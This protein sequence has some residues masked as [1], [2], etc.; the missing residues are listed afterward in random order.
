MITNKMFNAEEVKNECIQSIRDWFNENGKDCKAVVGLSGGK[1]S[2]IVAALCVE[3]LGSDR[4]IGIIMPDKKQ[5][6]ITEDIVNYFKIPNFYL[7]ISEIKNMFREKIIRACYSESI[8]NIYKLSNQAEIN[9]PARIRMNLL[10]T[11]AQCLNGRVMNTCNT[12]ENYVGYATV[13]GDASG[14][15]S[16]LHHLTVTEVKAVG[17]A[18]GLPKEFIEKTPEDG[19]CGKTDEE[20]FGFTY[21]VLDKYI[22]TGVCEDEEVKKK[23]D[24]MHN[25]NLFKLLPMACYR[26]SFLE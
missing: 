5:D 25:K 9:L 3:A 20:N 24:D 19:L 21:D 14:D 22:R 26:P 8:S 1:D 12:S 15:F 6:R 17:Y 10:R 4:V 18:L 11:Y 16:P 7:D 23:I 2:T 13:D